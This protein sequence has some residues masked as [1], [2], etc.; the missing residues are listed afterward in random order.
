MFG[1]V[2]RV[3]IM[4]SKLR[5]WFRG[6]SVSI[7]SHSEHAVPQ[8][9]RD[10][11]YFD[12]DKA[13][14]IYSQLMG[15]LIKERQSSKKSAEGWRIGAEI[16][17][18]GGTGETSAEKS[19]LE[20]RIMHH[21]ILTNLEYLLF[22]ND[23][24]VSIDS[25]LSKSQDIDTLRARL[26]D[27]G[28]VRAE[29]QVWFQDFTSINQLIANIREFLQSLSNY[30]ISEVL[31]EAGLIE[32][33]DEKESLQQQLKSERDRN[34]RSRIQQRIDQ[35]DNQ[36]SSVEEFITTSAS[37]NESLQQMP[38][39]L[40]HLVESFIKGFLENQVHLRVYP[41][42][43]IPE[44][45]L[46][47]RLKQE[48]FVDGTIDFPIFAYGSRPT[49]KLTVL[50]IVTSVPSEEQVHAL[51]ISISDD[52]ADEEKDMQEAFND[53]FQAVSDNLEPYSRFSKYPNV[54]IY[55]IAVYRHVRTEYETLVEL[56]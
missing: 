37:A 8:E 48:C 27:S 52:V 19:T 45:F 9:I 17:G 56:E 7:L 32:V 55:P 35:I 38:D 20:T 29:G 4:L 47:S 51:D 43:D 25:L 26:A 46:L 54:S 50:G 28:Y 31:K 36:L 30:Q 1:I 13:M 24:A 18:I 33:A 6:K 15:G 40:V 22:K 21:D 23:L 5:S 49:M 39:E 42:E 34:K 16:Y 44:F 41:F 10:L 2:Y 14:S 3:S 53:I 12:V 11:I